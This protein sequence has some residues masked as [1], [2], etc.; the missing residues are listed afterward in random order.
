MY[1][2]HCKLWL[3][4]GLVYDTITG[5]HICMMVCMFS[6]TFAKSIYILNVLANY[7]V[8]VPG[9][10]DDLKPCLARSHACLVSPTRLLALGQFL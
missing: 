7:L 6:R 8:S 5:A 1:V 10:M 2:W 3:C 4:Y 9:E